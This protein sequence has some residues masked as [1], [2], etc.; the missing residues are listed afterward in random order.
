MK[1]EAKAG[2]I[3]FRL[4]PDDRE[5]LERLR[6][7]YDEQGVQLSDAQIIRAAILSA[8]RAIGPESQAAETLGECGRRIDELPP[9]N[10][11][12]R[13]MRANPGA[14]V[15][16][17]TDGSWTLQTPYQWVNMSSDALSASDE[18]PELVEALCRAARLRFERE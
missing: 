12:A 4:K 9:L 1:N 5:R 10:G 2:P 18:L 17:D 8:E 3:H 7:H 6:A 16:L 13:L 11:T 15:Y 14:V